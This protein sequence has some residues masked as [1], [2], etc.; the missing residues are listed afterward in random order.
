M[1]KPRNQAAMAKTK[2]RPWDAADYLEY[3]EDV[4]AYLEAAFEDGDPR[5]IVA[6]RSPDPGE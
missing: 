6:G 1:P 2:T 3:P 5:L 4:V